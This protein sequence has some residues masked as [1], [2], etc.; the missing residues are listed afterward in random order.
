MSILRTYRTAVNRLPNDRADTRAR[1]L[2]ALDGV[3]VSVERRLTPPSQA[4][5]AG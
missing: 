5:G 1:L 3:A 4:P 2:A